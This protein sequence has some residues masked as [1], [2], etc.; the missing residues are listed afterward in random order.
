M[1]KSR[2]QRQQNSSLIFST[3]PLVFTHR[4]P[5][6]IVLLWE[7]ECRKT[8]GGG[9]GGKGSLGRLDDIALST[10]RTV[11]FLWSVTC[12]FFF[13]SLI[14]SSPPSL[15]SSCSIT[16][17]LSLSYSYLLCLPAFNEKQLVCGVSRR[18]WPCV[19]VRPCDEMAAALIV[20]HGAAGRALPKVII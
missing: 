5:A 3:L 20:W 15:L 1:V 14:S 8:R 16:S 11:R 19:R 7:Q 18:A 2:Q 4:L 10:P 13:Y 12:F 6:C 17:R 9:A